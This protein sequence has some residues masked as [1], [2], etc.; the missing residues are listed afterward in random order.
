MTDLVVPQAFWRREGSIG[1]GCLLDLRR[2]QVGTMSPNA[3]NPATVEWRIR[4]LVSG[5][6]C[7]IV[8]K[9]GPPQMKAATAAPSRTIETATTAILP[10]VDIFPQFACMRFGDFTWL[11]EFIVN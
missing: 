9:S 6:R 8:V 5:L 7:N 11:S 1:L 3:A 10:A 4:A 2:L